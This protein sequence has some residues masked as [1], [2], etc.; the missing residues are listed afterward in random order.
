L[1]AAAAFRKRA[2]TDAPP[3]HF[4]LRKEV[5]AGAGL[6]GGSS[7]AAA[8][9]RGL[10]QL[11]HHPLSAENLRAC[12]AEIGSDVPLFLENA[13][14]IM[15]GRGEKITALSAP[16]Q[17]ALRGRELLVFKPPFGVPTAWAYARLRERAP[18]W[19]VPAAEAEQKLAAWSAAPTW[20]MLPLEN[21]LEF[22]VFEKFAA[23]PVLLAELRERFNVRCR[24]SGSGSACFALLE[25]DSPR[26]AIT[27]AVRAA[28]G[29]S[30][31]IHAT[32][33]SAG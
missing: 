33:L 31:L 8:A 12:A 3:I 15:R 2:H 19:Y 11:A 24:M 10:N 17:A 13:P 14:V 27:T 29:P 30:A 4:I 26:E 20:A 6:G 25:P 28:W 18:A 1:K 22:P 16:A 21:N 9:L 32:R 23:L 7:D 5:P